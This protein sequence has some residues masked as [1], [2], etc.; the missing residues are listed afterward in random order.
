MIIKAKKTNVEYI[1]DLF[2]N[3][4]L[5]AE[6]QFKVILRKINARLDGSEYTDYTAYDKDG[7]TKRN[8]I[9]MRQYYKA[10]IV[11]FINPPQIENS[12]GKVMDLTPDSLFDGEYEGTDIE[13]LAEDIAIAIDE[14][15]EQRR[16][17]V[18]K[19]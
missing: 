17:L 8:P 10:H 7:K 14:I 9:S 12:H 4:T 16:K 18:K 6:K 1:T 3:K 13:D 19:S 5:P 2:D 11:E 15:A